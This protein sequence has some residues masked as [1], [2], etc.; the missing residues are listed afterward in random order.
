MIRRAGLVL[1]C[2]LLVMCEE[3]AGN[4]VTCAAAVNVDGVLYEE[5]QTPVDETT[6]SPE[7]YLTLSANP[8]CQDEGEPAGRLKPGQSNYLPAGTELHVVDGF[9]PSERLAFRDDLFDQWR[10][11]APVGGR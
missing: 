6:V 9:D 11:L 3:P 10:G 5:L 8:G 2:L 4:D 1:L 7:V